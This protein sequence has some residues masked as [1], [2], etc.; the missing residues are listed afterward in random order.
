MSLTT[1]TP[2]SQVDTSQRHGYTVECFRCHWKHIKT[3][4]PNHESGRETR[5][6][7]RCD[8]PTEHMV[9][10]MPRGETPMAGQ[11]PDV[12]PLQLPVLDR[13][14]A[15]HVETEE[16]V[17]ALIHRDF[18]GDKVRERKKQLVSGSSIHVWDWL[19]DGEDGEPPVWRPVRHYAADWGSAW[20]LAVDL[21]SNDDLTL[22]IEMSS[23]EEDAITTSVVAK[24][25]VSG[26]PVASAN[27]R[28][29]PL[30]LARL[31]LTI[32]A[33]EREA[34]EAHEHKEAG[35]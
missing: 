18:Y 21:L 24:D 33:S 17:N 13:T 9:E 30:A 20:Q 11:P 28:T 22:T 34:R 32:I 25:K 35:R 6:C 8:L 26:R 12:V 5:Y 3:L 16:W 27:A 14:T 19:K 23:A 29:G 10:K 2:T 1:A 15:A 4:P 31:V 7:A